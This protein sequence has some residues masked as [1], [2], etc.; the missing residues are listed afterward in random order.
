MRTTIKC[1]TTL[2]TPQRF[3]GLGLFF[4]CFWLLSAPSFSQDKQ[5]ST[6]FPI[7]LPEYK[8][9]GEAPSQ[10][11]EEAIWKL[12]GKFSKARASVDAETVASCFA[13][14][15]EWTN[16]FGDVVRGR[17]NLQKFLER[18]FSEDDMGTTEGESLGYKPISTRYLGEDV[19]ILHGVTMS[20][21]G[22]SRSGEGIRYVHISFVLEKKN[23]E[24]LITYQMIMDAR[25]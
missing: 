6:E 21:R 10:E 20:T 19:A 24:W 3:K 5:S 9:F 11:D 18:L 7:T 22:A 16:A 14:D 2:G 4:V 23:G 8:T 1:V 15:V 25:E 12:M 17:D 13:E